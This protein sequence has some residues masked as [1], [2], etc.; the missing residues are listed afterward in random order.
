MKKQVIQ[1]TCDSC[2]KEAI[3]DINPKRKDKGLKDEDFVLPDGWAHV[4]GDT[5][6]TTIFALDLCDECFAPIRDLAGKSGK[7]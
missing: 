6:T 1:S 7:K 3:T 2:H 5:N 4:R